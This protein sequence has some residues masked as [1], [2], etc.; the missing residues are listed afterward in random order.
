MIEKLAVMEFLLVGAITVACFAAPARRASL[1]GL[2][3][4]LDR[5]KR[6]RWQWLSIVAVMLILRLQRI[7]PP[8]VELTIGLLFL[9]LL[10]FPARQV[11][12]MRK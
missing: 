6:S 9:I 11:L 12:K 1:F 5:L 3:A 4:R 8:A 10:S 2:S 7:F